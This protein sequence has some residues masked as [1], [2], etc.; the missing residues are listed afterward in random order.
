MSAQKVGLIFTDEYERYNFGP[1]HPLRPLRVMLTYSLME[2]LGLLNNSKIEL[3]KPRL[4]TKEELERVHS[5]SYVEVVKRLSNNPE[6]KT[7]KPYI[8][9]LG[10]G[11]N[12]VFKG[13][14]EASALVCGAS[15]MA[16]DTVWQNNDFNIAF[17]PAGGLHHA[18]KN[19]ASGFCIFNDIAVAIKHLQNINKDIKIAYLD[20]DCHHGDGVQWIFYNDPNVLTISFHESGKF[21]FPGTGNVEEV[22]EGIGEGYSVNFP[23][24][25]G[26]SN[27]MFLKLFRNCVPEIL[28]AFEPDILVTQLGVDTHFNDPLTQMGLSIQAYKDIAVEMKK[29]AKDYCN[30]KW[31]ALGGGGYLMTVV[32]RAWTLFLA[33]MLDVELENQLPKTWI[34]EVKEKVPYEETPYV[35]WDRGDKIEVQL[36][37]HP[38]VAKKM[39]D[40][41][42]MLINVC[43]TKYI[44]KLIKM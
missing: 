42:D 10:P 38:E 34:R 41:T 18:M 23:L 21:L 36:L 43:Q 1:K 15:I 9:G 12:P 31:L 4:A 32:P 30:D 13:M 7:V 40:Y 16:A 3:L 33:A 27:K 19:R 28:K 29:Y 25:P 6:D 5:K 20:I 37:A 11:D 26:T 2:K 35:L 8:Y 24:L 22:G 17:N 39:V 14:Y 44:P